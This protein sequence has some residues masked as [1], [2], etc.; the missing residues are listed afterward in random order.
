MSELDVISLT[1]ISTDCII[2]V[3]PQERTTPQPL[4]IDLELHLDTRDAARGG[5]LADT[6]DYS[7]LAGEIRFL[8][9]SCQFLLLETAA[10]ALA[11]YLLAPPT[12]DVRRKQIERV[13]ITM[14]KPNALT[15]GVVPSLRVTRDRSEVRF[16][17][18]NKY[19]GKV[20]VMYETKGCGIYRL[21]IAPGKE[22]KSHIHKEMA[23]HELVLSRGLHL[24]GLPTEAGVAHAWPHEFPHRYDNPTEEEKT[25]LC[26]D[27]PGFNPLD[28][29]PSA[30]QLRTAEELAQRYF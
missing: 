7:Q 9:E 29:I 15:G 27:R 21:R 3:Y 4:S 19:F 28:E 20:D 30:L 26:V 24:Q 18:E 12:I 23:E 13:V 11:H 10:D 2:G 25:I 17:H 6:I 14:H 22:I 16:R 5:H 8:L 1:G